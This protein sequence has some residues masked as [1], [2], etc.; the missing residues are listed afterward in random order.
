[1]MSSQEVFCFLKSALVQL[2]PNTRILP[3]LVFDDILRSVQFFWL[4]MQLE[5]Q[6]VIFEDSSSL[7]KIEPW[8]VDEYARFLQIWGLSE[9]LFK[10]SELEFLVFHIFVSSFSAVIM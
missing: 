2:L 7:I 9:F 1:M 3:I 5:N 10:Q 4:Q 6:N 8:I